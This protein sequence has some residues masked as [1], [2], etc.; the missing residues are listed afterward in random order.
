[1]F[2]TKSTKRALVMSV[3]SLVLCVSMF[4]GTTFAWFTDS[5]TSTN[6]IIK[7]GSLDVEMYHSTDKTSWTDASQGAIFNYQYW[8]PGYTEV[9]YIKIKNVGDLAFKFQLNIIPTIAETGE[10][11]L[12]DVIDVYMFDANTTV[13]RATIDAANPVG[14]LAS[15]MADADGAAYGYLLPTA[16][17]DRYNGVEAPRGELTYCIALKMQE[18]AGN[19]YQNLSVGEGFS[20]QLLATQYTW[21]EDTFG[22]DYDINSEYDANQAVPMANV[23]Y[24]TDLIKVPTTTLNWNNSWSMV[25]G[26]S[27]VEFDTAYSFVAPVDGATAEKSPYANWIADFNV[28]FNR[29]I[30]AADKVGIAGEYG[31]F[32]WIG[33]L[34]EDP[35]LINFVNTNRAEGVDMLAA[36][37]D[38]ALSINYYELCNT[39]KEFNCSTW[40]DEDAGE[41]L[42]I[43]VE[44]RLYETY[45]ADEAYEKFGNHSTNYKKADYETDGD[46]YV[47]IGQYTY[48][49]GA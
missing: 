32:N 18:S 16:G 38:N 6:N 5:V 25:N 20:V 29:D 39:V 11:N 2:K 30:T 12:A 41:P 49:Y 44:L 27:G 35:D 26:A 43:T 48:T 14:T 15:L 46:Y 7:S 31:A 42:T 17:S 37:S 24:L 36:Y 33:F 22:D 1:M 9:K 47:V 8:E 23:S 40:A 13:D 10:F 4:V 28:K 21:E 3:L 45:T 34:A 19:D